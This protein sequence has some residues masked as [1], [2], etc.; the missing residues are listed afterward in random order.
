MD[1]VTI[2]ANCEDGSM[3]VST[4]SLYAEGLKQALEKDL[5]TSADILVS[6]SQFMANWV[7]NNLLGDVATD[8]LVV[9]RNCPLS[10]N[11]IQITDKNRAKTQRVLIYFGRMEERKGFLLFL[12][13]INKMDNKPIEVIFIGGDC[14]IQETRQ[15]SEIAI[16]QLSS[17][18][19]PHQ[20]HTGLQRSDALTKLKELQG[21]MLFL[22]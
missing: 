22:P 9:Q 2:M 17:L 13:A 8:N 10:S 19:I 18:G 20:F 6:P 1:K 11:R 3:Q 15:A 21:V 5:I 7:K 14:I 12:E 16:E 4:E